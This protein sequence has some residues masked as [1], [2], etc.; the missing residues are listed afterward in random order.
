MKYTAAKKVVSSEAKR[1]EKAPLYGDK[2]VKKPPVK[3]SPKG[4]PRIFGVGTFQR[5]SDAPRVV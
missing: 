4:K 5:K 1:S 2:A 3:A